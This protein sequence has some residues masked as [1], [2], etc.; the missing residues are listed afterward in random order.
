[1]KKS[2]DQFLSI[3]SDD[4]K[5]HHDK[6]MKLQVKWYQFV[7]QV[8]VRQDLCEMAEGIPLLDVKAIVSCYLQS[9]LNVSFKLIRVKQEVSTG[10]ARNASAVSRYVAEDNASLL[11][12][13]SLVLLKRE[14]HSW[15]TVPSPKSKCIFGKM[16][17]KD[18]NWLSK[19]VLFCCVH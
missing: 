17:Q 12:L 2:R 9:V 14:K 10:I 11:K 7:W 1:M 18:V 19:L 3:F 5:G 16:F 8:L 6:Y 13:G 15:E 4:V